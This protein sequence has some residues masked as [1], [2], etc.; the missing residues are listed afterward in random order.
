[1][2]RRKELKALAPSTTT[3]QLAANLA[4]RV[5]DVLGVE[6]FSPFDVLALIAANTLN[7]AGLRLKAA[8][9]LARY[10]RPQVRA[11]AIETHETSDINITIADFASSKTTPPPPAPAAEEEPEHE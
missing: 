5:K 9:E 11:L 2:S 3:V 8:A 6:N 10:Y 4:E 7:D 1:M